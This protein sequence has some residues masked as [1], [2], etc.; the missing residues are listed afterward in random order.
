M[1]DERDADEIL[2]ECGDSE[3]NTIDGDGSFWDNGRKQFA[4][5]FERE[6]PAG[7]VT[8]VGTGAKSELALLAIDID[9]NVCQKT[10][11]ILNNG[12]TTPPTGTALTLT[13]F[14]GSNYGDGGGANPITLGGVFTGK[15]AFCYRESS[16]SQRYIYLHVLRAR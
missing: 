8:G 1:G 14:S 10:N 9:A 5:H 12:W 6:Q 7:S 2:F 16:G 4:G 3:R 11:E 15:K 13:R